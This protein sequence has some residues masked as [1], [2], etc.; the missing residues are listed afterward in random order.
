MIE[1]PLVRHINAQ[2]QSLALYLH[3]PSGMRY[4]ASLESA[5]SYELNPLYGQ[6][7][8]AT[9]RSTIWPIRR[10]GSA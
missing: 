1:S 5:W 7:R 8:H 4:A 2:C 3:K 9:P 6:A 10:F